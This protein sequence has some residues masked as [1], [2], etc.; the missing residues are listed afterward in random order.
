MNNLVSNH[1]SRYESDGEDD[2]YRRQIPALF[3]VERY[4]KPGTTGGRGE[5]RTRLRRGIESEKSNIRG[6]GFC[7]A[8]KRRTLKQKLELTGFASVGSRPACRDH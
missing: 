6:G 2:T 8:K 3:G 7:W 4:C 5:R 1:E